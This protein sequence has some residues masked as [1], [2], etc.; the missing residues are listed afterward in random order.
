MRS[1]S[2]SLITR[3]Q[4]IGGLAGASVAAAMAPSLALGRGTAPARPPQ[5]P[6]ARRAPGGG[7]QVTEL[8]PGA[9]MIAGAGGNTTVRFGPDHVLAVDS[10]LPD[11][12]EMLLAAVTGLAPD[13]PATLINT[14]WHFDHAGGNKAF[15]DAGFRLLASANCRKRLASGGRIDFYQRDIP[16]GEP[17]V[18]PIAGVV[19]QIELDAGGPVSCT[20][21]PPAHTDG[22]LTVHLHDADV[23]VMGD[24][25]F[26]GIYPF[27]DYSSGANVPGIVAAADAVL[28]QAGAATKIVPGHGPLA[29][30]QALR[31][32]RDMLADVHGRVAA[33]IDSGTSEDDA[34]AAKPTAAHDQAWARGFFQ[35]EQFTRIVYRTILAQRQPSPAR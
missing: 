22:D 2:S 15:A 27:I 19:G 13:R 8:A 14:H 9:H 28:A 29:D 20:A 30:A 17:R 23:I 33:L 25:F 31:R 1:L 10:G 11:R 24:I 5:T 32:Y 26:N 35:G 18:L 12:A 7:L 21:R 6:P 16:P 34:V 4:L 3:R